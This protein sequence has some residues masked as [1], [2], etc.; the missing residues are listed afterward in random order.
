MNW[1]DGEVAEQ[2]ERA[3][4]LDPTVRKQAF[5]FWIRN[6][7]LLP[8]PI[9]MYLTKTEL[10]MGEWQR[11]VRNTVARCSCGIRRWIVPTGSLAFYPP[12]ESSLMTIGPDHPSVPIGS[13]GSDKQ[14][15]LVEIS[16]A[17][18]RLKQVVMPYTGM[19]REAVAAIGFGTVGKSSQRTHTSGSAAT[20]ALVDLI[21]LRSLAEA[22]Q[23]T[24]GK[25]LSVMSLLSPGAHLRHTPAQAL[26]VRLFGIYDVDPT[27]ST[28][29]IGVSRNFQVPD[30]SATPHRCS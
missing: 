17:D 19:P 18:G 26:Q 20:D 1:L 5:N 25:P 15:T 21:S 23:H 30:M 10:L 12:S 14:S 6:R 13:W 24:G 22:L 4:S 9:C 2:W 7:E 27:A 8:G 28:M 11:I 16:A 29:R 3:V